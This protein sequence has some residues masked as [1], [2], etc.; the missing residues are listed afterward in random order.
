MMRTMIGA[1]MALC[2]TATAQAQT[3]N[4]TQ[5]KS[6]HDNISAIG[7][8][9]ADD[10]L[11]MRDRY[12]YDDAQTV[13]KQV[14]LSLPVMPDQDVQLWLTDHIAQIMS[15]TPTL[16]PAHKAKVINL[17][18]GNGWPQLEQQWQQAHIPDIVMQKNY[19]LTTLVTDTPQIF[20]KGRQQPDGRVYRWI[21]DAP[22]LLTYEQKDQEPQ[23]FHLTLRIGLTRIP[24]RED[25]QL[26]A[27]D[28][29][30]VAPAVAP[31]ATSPVATP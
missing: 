30:G 29:W 9:L 11:P 26:I 12:V 1:L 10:T 22:I 21:V 6:L 17:F 31:I 24:M 13:G 18:T 14:A 8:G 19:A 28:Q 7:Q 5:T 4:Q 3:Q 15:V 2:L 25:G 16:Y 20:A 27:I 23:S